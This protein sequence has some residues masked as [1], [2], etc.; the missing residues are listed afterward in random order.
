MSPKHPQAT[1][2]QS[3]PLSQYLNS[4]DPCFKLRFTFL[5]FFTVAILLTFNKMVDSELLIM[6]VPQLEVIFSIV[7]TVQIGA[8]DLLC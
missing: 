1:F 2:N 6:G 4:H 5:S 8:L 7:R 3:K